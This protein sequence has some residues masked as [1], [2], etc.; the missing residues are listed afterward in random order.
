MYKKHLAYESSLRAKF[1]SIK[2]GRKGGRHAGKE[3]EREGGTEE[4]GPWT[5]R[6]GMEA[7][8]KRRK[9]GGRG[10]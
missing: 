1:T 5:V 3:E 9:G 10:E 6:R 2:R 4:E 8:Q 7:E